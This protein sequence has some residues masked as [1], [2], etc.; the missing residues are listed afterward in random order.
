MALAELAPVALHPNPTVLSEYPL[1]TENP[2][3]HVGAVGRLAV[4]WVRPAGRAANHS[5][6][7][8]YLSFD[9]T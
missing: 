5:L 3:P 7:W 9:T 2:T 6:S 1:T 4:L 8:S